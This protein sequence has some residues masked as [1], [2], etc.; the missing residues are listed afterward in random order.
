MPPETSPGGF[1]FDRAPITV[2]WEITRACAL[3]CRHCRAE[4][5]PRRHRQELTTE[6]G[7]DLID[8][9][10]ATGTKVLVI[11]GGDPLM[12]RDVFRLMARA[13]ER[14]LRVGFSPSVT[15]LLRREALERALDSGMTM[16]HISLD[17]PNPEVHDGFRGV[18]GSF[19]RTVEVLRTASEL[20]V[21]LQ[22]GTTVTRHNLAHLPATASLLRQFQISMWSV[23]FLVPTG[24]GQL[25]D[26]ISP[27]EHEAVYH[28][29]FDLS[30]QVPYQIRTTAAPA[31]RR[32]VLQ[33]RRDAATA[34]RYL[35]L[36]K[37][38]YR[39]TG[40]NDG[41]GFAFVSHLGE[42]F[43]SGFLQI[44][45]DSVRRRPFSEIYRRSEVFV[46]LRRPELLRGKCGFCEFRQICGGS[47]AR[48]YALT[49][50]YLASEPTCTYVPQG[51]ARR[52]PGVHPSGAGAPAA[53]GSPSLGRAL[54]FDPR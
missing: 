22:V 7:F 39:H 5:Q 40:I 2:A 27:A 1:D 54:P 11:T 21:D 23:F 28:W 41:K 8:D 49:G 47:R 13:A 17:G 34:P 42:V 10:A 6:E 32:V 50:D 51:L 38:P 43:P 48:A 33:R 19:A 44:A 16:L 45:V 26:M 29:L 12:R 9:I 24:R 18:R 36:D 4:A 14:G 52:R 46:N 3:V 37:E 15:A 30:G 31:Y 25:K 20:N 53:E 35:F